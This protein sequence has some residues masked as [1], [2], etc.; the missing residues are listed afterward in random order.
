MKKILIYITAAIV[1]LGNV[2]CTDFLDIDPT[3]RFSSKTVWEN[4][5][6]LRQYVIGFYSILKESCEIGGASYS[7]CNIFSDAYS[8]IMKSSSWDQY[9]HYFNMA[10]LQET[11]FTSD[12]AGPFAC[13][14]GDSGM[15]TR[16]RRYNEFLR[17]APNYVS[18]Y[19][20]DKINMW[21]A[22]VRFMR[23]FAYFRLIR[24]YGPVIIRDAVDGPEQNDKP[25]ATLADSWD[26]VMKDLEF[27]GTY[28]PEKWEDTESGR[29]TKAAAYGFMS[30]VALYAERWGDVITAAD[31]CAEFGGQ[32]SLNPDG[33]T[34]KGAYDAEE[35]YAKVF[36]NIS[37]PENLLTVAFKSDIITND[38]EV[39][40]RPKGDTQFHNNANVFSAIAPTSELVD[41]YEIYDEASASWKDFDWNISSDDPYAGRDPRFYATILYNGAKWEDRI[42][43][44]YKG[45]LDGIAE[46]KT[47]GTA[48]STVTGYYLRKW[49]TEGDSQ[50]EKKGGI[51][52]AIVLRYAEVL[53]NKAEAQ[54][55][56][57]NEPEALITL[58]MIRNRVGMPALQSG[59]LNRFVDSRI[60]GDLPFMAA[61]RHERMVELAGEGFRWWDVRRWKIGVELFNNSTVHGTEITGTTVGEGEDKVVTAPWTYK[62]VD[63]DGGRHR[64]F[65]E[66]YYAFS[67]PKSEVANNASIG[68]ANNNPGW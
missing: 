53:L 34:Y 9:N 64:F 59:D 42:V 1:A 65:F 30:R 33:Y 2:S 67:L 68:I 35:A 43:E 19:G 27:A 8:D 54:F 10:M 22:E 3:D 37:N 26:F 24:V 51:H 63:V 48:T 29:V 50:W 44:S 62:Q 57:G 16:I 32:L 60:D 55:R 17:D 61:L 28:L 41:S 21:S 47:T 20:Q 18:M 49:I 7:K 14:S 23:A 6:A 5:Q 45:G 38:A 58:N 39:A 12:D 13:W 4:E 56:S 52:F 25:R 40:F 66:K 46:F 31:K 15:Y 36:N 11:Y